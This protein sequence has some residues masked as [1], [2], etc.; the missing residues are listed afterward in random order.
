M[1]RRR[2]LSISTGLF[3]FSLL[4]AGLQ[5]EVRFITKSQRAEKVNAA[6]AER[7]AAPLTG[8]WT[9]T[10]AIMFDQASGKL[11]KPTQL[12][13]AGMLRTIQQLT[14]KPARSI[15][16]RVTSDGAAMQGSINGA[17]ATVVLARATASGVMETRCVQT[18]E[19][20]TEFLGLAQ[21][22]E[23]QQ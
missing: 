3:A 20:A 16:G 11:R 5:A 15:K 9:G 22:T 12:E 10:K 14:T 23:S 7:Q 4:A 19:E 21:E 8:R 2:I 18:F 13:V 6:A 1:I 17:F